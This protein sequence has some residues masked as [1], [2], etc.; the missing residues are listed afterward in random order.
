[1][2]QQIVK[3][4][5]SQLKISS[6]KNYGHPKFPIEEIKAFQIKEGVVTG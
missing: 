6:K 2:I 4:L 1:V 3:E 5:Q